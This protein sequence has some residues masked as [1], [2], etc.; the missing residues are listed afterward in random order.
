MNYRLVLSLLVTLGMLEASSEARTIYF[1]T[2]T[3]TIPLIYGGPT[4]LRFPS[5]VRTISQA[6]K[7][8]I[9]PA[10][11]EQPNYA[12]LSV[13]PRFMTGSSDVA[14]ILND[15]TIIKTRL[16]VISKAIPEK[17]DS[18]YDFKSKENLLQKEDSNQPGASLPEFELMKAVIRDD[19]VAG[20]EVKSLTRTLTPGFKGVTI[21]LVRI[22]TG[23]QFNGYVFEITNITKDQKLF[24]NVQNLILGDPNLALLSMVDQTVIEPGSSKNKTYLRII[25]KSTSIYNELKLPIQVVSKEGKI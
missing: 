23:N 1:G 16:T 15:G 14:F 22:Y 25:A 2:Q 21:K 19:A 9:E 8:Q 17:T 4:I 7:F 11:A 5:E 13:Q 12:L 10:N 20:Y 24:I 18:I 3:E 6:Q